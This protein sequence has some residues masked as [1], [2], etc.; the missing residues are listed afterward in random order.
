MYSHSK[1]QTF[2]QCKLK[3]KLKYI[4]KIKPPIKGSIEGHLGSTVHAALEWLYQEIMKSNLPQLDNVL[5]K[6]LETW[7]K[8][9]SEE[10]IIVKKDMTDQDYL[11][12]GVKFLTDYYFKNHPFKDGTLETE[13]KIF[14]KI[15]D[16]NHSLMGFIDRLVHN[17]EL[18]RFEIHDYKTASSLPNQEYFENDRQLALYSIAIKEQYKKDVVLT[19]HYLNHNVQIFSKRTDNQLNQLLEEIKQ[20]IEEIEKTKEFPANKTILCDWCEYRT[21]CPAWGNKDF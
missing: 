17:K 21:I 14:I 4:D 11:N 9:F 3:Y 8:N 1:L 15:K 18:N 19:W 6:Y 20:L 10:L 5:E 13:K 7:Q 12:K 16:T 2:E